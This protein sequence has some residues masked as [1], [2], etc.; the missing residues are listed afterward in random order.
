[1]RNYSIRTTSKSGVS[2][3]EGCRF[4][5][6]WVSEILLE[7]IKG[8]GFCTHTHRE[9]IYVCLTIVHCIRTPYLY[10]CCIK[11]ISRGIC[12]AGEL[13]QTYAEKSIDIIYKSM[14]GYL[15]EKGQDQSH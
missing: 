15:K 4:T 12:C 14:L 11:Y 6:I 5:W 8:R 2:S 9:A 10:I 3:T 1:M 13:T 7:K